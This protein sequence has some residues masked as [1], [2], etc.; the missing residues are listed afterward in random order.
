MKTTRFVRWPHSLTTF[1]S[2]IA[3]SARMSA[4]TFAGSPR[5][6]FT[7]TRK[8]AVP[9]LRH[10]MRPAVEP[11]Y[12]LSMSGLSVQSTTLHGHTQP[13]P[14]RATHRAQNPS[15]H[16]TSLG[17]V[18][19]INARTNPAHSSCNLQPPCLGGIPALTWLQ[20]PLQSSFVV[21]SWLLLEYPRQVP[22]PT[23][24]FHLHQSTY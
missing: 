12:G 1:G 16:E 10:K 20:S 7:L 8:V 9:D 24:P 4:P 13:L 15:E 19:I 6:A 17:L 22:P 11:R 5:C 3:L 23:L 18:Y 2:E 21:S 14:P